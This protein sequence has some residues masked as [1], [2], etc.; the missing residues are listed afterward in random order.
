MDYQLPRP[1][2]LPELAALADAW[3]MAAVESGRRRPFL[4]GVADAQGQL[5]ATTH[6]TALRP[7]HD[8]VEGM[9]ALHYEARLGGH[10]NGVVF[11]VLFVKS[12]RP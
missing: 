4:I 7:V 5:I 11:D 12:R 3:R 1:D 8:V 10:A 6:T 9:Q 2:Q